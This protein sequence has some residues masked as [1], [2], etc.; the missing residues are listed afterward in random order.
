MHDQHSIAEARRNLPRLIHEA[1]LGKT[2]RLT[3]HGKPVA[4][5]IA[6]RTF[7]RMVAGRRSFVNAYEEFTTSVDLS[8]LAFDPAEL[9]EGV[10]DTKPGRDFRL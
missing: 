1:E 7:E 10:R 8:D 3:R 5:I 2:V 6:M 4:V 9:L